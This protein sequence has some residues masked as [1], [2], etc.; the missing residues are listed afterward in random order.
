MI[1]AKLIFKALSLDRILLQMLVILNRD[2]VLIEEIL[3]GNCDI[4]LLPKKP[5]ICTRIFFP[6]ICSGTI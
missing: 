5:A 4:S 1:R 6:N 3:M 2:V